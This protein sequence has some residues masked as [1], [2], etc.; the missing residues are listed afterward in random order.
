MRS[1]GEHTKLQFGY[2]LNSVG[3]NPNVVAVKKSGVKQNMRSLQSDSLLIP[4]P[5]L[6][7][8]NF[9]QV[10]GSLPYIL[11]AFERSCLLQDINFQFFD[12]VGYVCPEFLLWAISGSG[13]GAPRRSYEVLETY[14]DTILKLAATLCAY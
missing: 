10:L 7:K 14:G 6:N 5:F 1:T 8:L 2:K 3:P 9:H 11:N 4:H 12:K 13:L